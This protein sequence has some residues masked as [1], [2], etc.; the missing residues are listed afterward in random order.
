MFRKYRQR[1]GGGGVALYIQD[2]YV[3][4]EVEIEVGGR[5]VK[6]LGKDKRHKKSQG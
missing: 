2:V 6:C 5:P 4:T 1:K 3:C